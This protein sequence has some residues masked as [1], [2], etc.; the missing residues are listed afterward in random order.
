MSN[1]IGVRI[2][3]NCK[4]LLQKVCKARGEDLYDFVRRSIL[5][6]LASLSFLPETSKKAL[7]VLSVCRDNREFEEETRNQEKR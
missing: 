5:K 3:D 2:D 1:V 4:R 6:E 7:G